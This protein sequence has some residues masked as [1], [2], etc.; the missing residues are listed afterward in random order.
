MGAAAGSHSLAALGRR[1]WSC[2]RLGVGSILL[3]RISRA[4]ELF[5]GG[6]R[7]WQSE[8]GHRGCDPRRRLLG[9]RALAALVGHA[10]TAQVS[11]G[12]RRSALALLTYLLIDIGICTV[13]CLKRLV[14][15]V[16][17]ALSTADSLI[18]ISNDAAKRPTVA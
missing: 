17:I 16:Y 14:I 12:P 3:G 1:G 11:V 6:D 8:D 7:N 18:F 9:G 13:R 2:E 5:N 4:R 15:A 10:A